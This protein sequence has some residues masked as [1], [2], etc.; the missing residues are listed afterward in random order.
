M[1]DRRYLGTRGSSFAGAK[2]HRVQMFRRP[3]EDGAEGWLVR[4]DY[5]LRKLSVVGTIPRE[6]TIY[7]EVLKARPEVNAVVHSH[8]PMC[9]ALSLADKPVSCI[10]MQSFRFGD[11]VPI[12]PKPIY[13]KV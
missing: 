8:A 6:S 4:F 3:E 10:H 2:G 1:G 11:G 5:S 13:I 7:A 9:V 12:Y